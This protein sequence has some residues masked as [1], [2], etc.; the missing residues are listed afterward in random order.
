M[1]LLIALL[2]VLTLTA[3]NE[4]GSGDASVATAPTVDPTLPDEPSLPVDP[5]L[6]DDPAD[7]PVDVA[8][9]GT[10]VDPPPVTPPVVV[11]GDFNCVKS[12]PHVFCTGG[13]LGTD[14]GQLDL[15]AT[16]TG[17]NPAARITNITVTN[18]R[19]ATGSIGI[20]QNGTQ[21]TST[22]I[23]SQPNGPGCFAKSSCVQVT[24]TITGVAQVYKFMACGNGFNR[25]TNKFQSL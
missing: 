6:P 16:F 18:D 10:I 25:S 20:L 19:I 1:K 24:M 14:I 7:E 4:S 8:D 2:M 22:P 12:S 9:P 13:N 5:A 23:C 17:G 21:N 15:A 11:A 3:C